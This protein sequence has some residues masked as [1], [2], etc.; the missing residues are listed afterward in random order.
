[1]VEQNKRAEQLILPLNQEPSG[2]KRV[3]QVVVGWKVEKTFE[4]WTA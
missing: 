1:M 2:P 4:I 3:E